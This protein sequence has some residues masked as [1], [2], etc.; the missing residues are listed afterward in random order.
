LRVT[1]FRKRQC[2]IEINAKKVKVLHF[3]Q[4]KIPRLPYLTKTLC[5]WEV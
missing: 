3:L 1:F 2:I 4:K 5:E